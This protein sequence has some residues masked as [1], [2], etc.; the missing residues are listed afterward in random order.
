MY[1]TI[2]SSSCIIHYATMA[3]ARHEVLHKV[4]S[5][6][7][8]F[9]INSINHLD[10]LHDN[11]FLSNHTIS[12]AGSGNSLE[13]IAK[14][15]SFNIKYYA[16]SINQFLLS[17]RVNSLNKVGLR[18][19]L[20]SLFN[21][22]SELSH[23]NRIGLNID[24]I[25]ELL[26][27]HPTNIDALHVYCGTN[28]EDASHH[29]NTITKLVNISKEYPF[30][31]HINI[32]GGFPTTSNKKSKDFLKEIA[33]HWHVAS[34]QLN[35]QLHIE[36]GR[37]LVDNAAKLYVRV[38]DI[39]NIEGATIAVV[40]SSYTVYPRKILHRT[41]E[42]NV[43]VIGKENDTHATLTYV[44]GN[45]TFTND[46]LTVCQ[47]PKL[48]IGDIICIANAGAY[49]ENSY[50]AYLGADIPDIIIS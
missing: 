25:T 39:K 33:N 46:I 21:T 19:N 42:D 36:P 22:T 27:T 50:L 48:S 40:N 34:N 23:I 29:I 16:D 43:Y 3:N 20:N 45:T 10:L 1:K 8:G 49:V 18:I 44:C 12:F 26:K 41:N 28:L 5:C 31:K 15:L 47:L 6:G 30:I 7:I 14:I 37:G 35:L 13:D 38:H 24:D 9:F 11:N 2:F 17:T 32:G 4:H